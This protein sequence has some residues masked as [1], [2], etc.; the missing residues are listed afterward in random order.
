MARF[1]LSIICVTVLAASALANDES[2][3]F[4]KLHKIDQSGIKGTILLQESTEGTV[5]SGTATGLWCRSGG[6]T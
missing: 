5:V 4:A 1:F 6:V 3:A 2:V